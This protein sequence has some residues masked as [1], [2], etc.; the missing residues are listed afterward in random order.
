MG[1]NAAVDQET[2]DAGVGNDF[3]VRTHR[4]YVCAALTIACLEEGH[5]GNLACSG[6]SADAVSV[7]AGLAA[8]Y[9]GDNQ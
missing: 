1:R 6:T 7:P 4:E 3:A 2:I 8:L 5:I 9:P